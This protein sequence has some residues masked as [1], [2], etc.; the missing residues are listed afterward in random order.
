M[1]N[2]IKLD[3]HRHAVKNAT[4]LVVAF[5]LRPYSTV[6]MC[7]RIKRFFAPHSHDKHGGAIKKFKEA[8]KA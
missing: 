8:K 5:F 6:C 7:M 3:F 1:K 4:T 2:F